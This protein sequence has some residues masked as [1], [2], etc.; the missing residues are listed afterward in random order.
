MTYLGKT[1]ETADG[2]TIDV[3][4]IYLVECSDCGPIDK[5]ENGDALPETRAD[6]LK[7]QREHHTLHAKWHEE[8]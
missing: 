6:A 4:R 8:A 1:L 5:Y 3:A 7:A 2:Y